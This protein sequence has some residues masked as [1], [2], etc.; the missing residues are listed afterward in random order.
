MPYTVGELLNINTMQVGGFRDQVVSLP[1]CTHEH[2]E[3]KWMLVIDKDEFFTC[4]AE[5]GKRYQKKMYSNQLA[6]NVVNS[7]NSSSGILF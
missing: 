7:M 3:D 4:K 2:H 6:Y 1:L 5:V